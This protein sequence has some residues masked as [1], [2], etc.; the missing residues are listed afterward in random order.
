MSKK[1]PH[2]AGA[3]NR[4]RPYSYTRCRGDAGQGTEARVV[5]GVV[6]GRDRALARPRARP[7]DRRRQLLRRPRADQRLHGRVPDPEP[8]P[9]ARRR[10]RALVRVRPRLQRAAREGG[11][12]AR[13]AGRLDHLLALPPRRRRRHGALHPRRAAVHA[14][15]HGRL[16]RPDGDAL[17]DPLPD[18][19]PARHVRDRHRDPEQLRR[20]LDSGADA[21]RLEP[22]D[23]RR[24]HLR[25]AAGRHR[26][27][28]A[29]R[30][31]RLDPDRHRDPAAAAA[32][33]AA[34]ARRASPPRA[35]HSR[36]GRQAGLHADG[37]GDAR[38]RPDQ[39]QRRH[40]HDRGVEVDRPVH[41]PERDRQGLPDLHAPARDVLGRGRDRPLPD[42]RPAR[43][44]GRPGRRAQH[45]RARA[46]PDQLPPAARRAPSRS[47]WPSRSS[48]CST[49]AARSSPARRTSSPARSP[50]SR[51]AS[52]STG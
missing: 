49:S 5:D 32:A 51:S 15:A 34:R 16:R 50:R 14:G 19:R 38:A 2:S 52:P 10:R 4:S 3:R 45:D 47:S 31:R 27:A 29:L 9:R 21:G 6:L 8:D 41:L 1:G 13:L 17:A 26:D 23:H 25:R 33:V 37:A 35:R 48:A 36:S 24:A 43:D 42:A 39:C 46:A 7:R 40:R 18:R 28:E 20:V 22:R 44:P 30:L 11:E 12:G